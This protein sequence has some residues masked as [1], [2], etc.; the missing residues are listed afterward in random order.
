[1][2]YFYKEPKLQ[3]KKVSFNSEDYLYIQIEDP[4]AIEKEQENSWVYVELKSFYMLKEGNNLILAN[5]LGRVYTLT[6]YTESMIKCW[7]QQIKDT[8]G[9]P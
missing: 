1:M 4:N 5:H 2:S 3:F 6:G 7:S 9:F 8:I